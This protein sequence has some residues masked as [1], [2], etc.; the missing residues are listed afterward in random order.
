MVVFFD[1]KILILKKML[2]FSLIE[3]GFKMILEGFF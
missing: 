1:E 2:V 3:P